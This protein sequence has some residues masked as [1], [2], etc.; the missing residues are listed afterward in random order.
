MRNVRSRF[1]V[2]FQSSALIQWMSV[3][4]NVA[5]P[6]RERTDLD[7]NKIREKVEQCLNWVDLL[8][9]ADR[10]PTEVSGG[11]QKRAG[12]ARAIIIN[13]EIL[14]YDEPTSGLDP[15]TS[16]RIDK[17]IMRTNREQNQKM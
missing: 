13:P 5:L 16:R 6:L 17:L 10:F 9:A 14:L 12:L 15:V 7:E 3:Y 4:D 2:L 11:M 1:G 8:D